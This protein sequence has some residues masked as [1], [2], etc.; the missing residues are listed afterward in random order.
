MKICLVVAAIMISVAAFGQCPGS[1]RSHLVACDCT[2]LY[3]E[4]SGCGG[5]TGTC[6]VVLPGNFCGSD[7]NGTSCYIGST[8][9][10]CLSAVR[11]QKSWELALADTS[12]ARAWKSVLNDLVSTCGNVP[13]PAPADLATLIRELKL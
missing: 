11:P 5:I 2:G 4:G 7:G 1:P 9:T 8:T 6:S 3:S 13:L 12:I 10:Q